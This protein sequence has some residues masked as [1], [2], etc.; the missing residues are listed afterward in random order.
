MKPKIRLPLLQT[1]RDVQETIHAQ[2]LVTVCEEA[3]CPNISECWSGGTATFMVMGDVCTRGCRFCAVKTAVSGKEL[4][5]EEPR[6][7]AETIHSWGLTYVVV[8]S[9]DRDDLPDQ[10]ASHFAGCVR[11]IRKSNPQ[12]KIEV[13]IPDFRGNLDCLNAIIA[14][15]P[16]VIA[17]NIEVVERLQAKVRDRRADYRQSL[18][19]LRAIKELDATRCTKSSIMVGFGESTEEVVAAMRDLRKNGVDFL[20]IGQYLSPGFRHAPVR[21]YVAPEK[22]LFYKK[23]GEEMGFRYVASGALVRSSYRAGEYFERANN[24]LYKSLD[25]HRLS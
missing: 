22:F 3:H 10:G 13:L 4:D 18:F 8:T 16:D 2:K 7:L 11:E 23:V 20:T 19:V 14:A 21:E 12:I 6:R 15:N 24:N 9:V 1:F 17:H 25:S 5:P